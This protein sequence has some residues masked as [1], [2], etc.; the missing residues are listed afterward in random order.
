M[1]FNSNSTPSP[2]GGEARVACALG[3][4]KTRLSGPRVRTSYFLLSSRPPPFPSP[5]LF[6][7]P[8]NSQ[9]LS[10]LIQSEFSISLV[11]MKQILYIKRRIKNEQDSGKENKKKSRPGAIRRQRKEPAPRYSY[12][13]R[14][15][16]TAA[17]NTPHNRAPSEGD[18]NHM[19]LT[20]VTS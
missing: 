1:G 6:E 16:H 20:S 3:R 11:A 12:E 17:N 10:L 5:V 19:A 18:T 9:H 7:D 14:S 4:A 13:V 2:P 15:V 8:E